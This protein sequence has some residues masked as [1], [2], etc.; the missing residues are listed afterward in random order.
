MRPRAHAFVFVLLVGAAAAAPLVAVLGGGHTLVWRDTA[1][2]GASLQRLTGTALR[3]LRLPQWNPHEAMGLPLL[4][5]P[6][7]AV[8]HPLTVLPAWVAPEAGLDWQIVLAVALA[9]AGAAL[10]ALTLGA[11]RWASAA[12]GVGWALSGY[13]L[14]MSCNTPYL[15]AGASA[16]WTAA[17]LLLAGKGSPW[18][19]PLAAL[20]TAVQLFAGDMQWALFVAILGSC[21][22]MAVGGWRGA[23]RASLAVALGALLGAV[24]LLP[25]WHFFAESERFQGLSP[26]ERMQ[27]ALAPWRLLEL[28]APGFFSG[29]SLGAASTPVFRALG[30]PS[31]LSLPFAPSVF[32]GAPVL[33]LAAAGVRAHRT[34]KVLAVAA[35]VA[36]WIALGYHLGADQLLRYVPVV[37]AFRY[38]EKLVGPFTLCALTLAA[39]GLDLVARGERKRLLVLA[40]AVAGVAAAAAL[41]LLAA[42][43]AGRQLFESVG[44]GRAAEAARAQLGLG[45]VHAAAA[46]AAVAAVLALAVG[47]RQ[48]LAAPALAASIVA[49]SAVAAP[50]AVHVGVP[51]E[52]SSPS[53]A[54]IAASES[55]PRISTPLP[56]NADGGRVAQVL[57]EG[58]GDLLDQFMAMEREM[59]VTSYAAAMGVGNVKPYAP[60]LPRRTEALLAAIQDET[61]LRRYGVTHVVARRALSFDDRMLA[62]AS[63][64]GGRHV[65]D[66]PFGRFEVWAV[67]HRPW[68]AFASSA[69]AVP[70]QDDAVRALVESASLGRTAVIVEAGTAPETAAGE[71]LAV[72]RAPERIL[73]D[74]QASGHGLLVVNDAFA[75]GWTA[76][77]DGRDVPILAA[78]VAV[79]AVQFPPGRHAL[80]M[81]YVAPGLRT[82]QALSILGLLVA[83]ALL[84]RAVLGARRRGDGVAGRGAS[85]RLADDVRPRHSSNE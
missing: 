73:I 22:A 23:V 15:L 60:T 41:F 62:E 76:S 40:V 34:A 47:P 11:S 54:A 10:L 51:L 63:T 61:W 58:G 56:Q 69:I 75:P 68:A 42:P 19:L 79:R 18:G 74:A 25:S 78:D 13:L 45:L 84:A 59:G 71:V 20:A 27:W 9:G 57:G 12:A 5:R 64:A 38:S 65:F 36:L 81:R 44:A 16:P 2:I 66:D 82:G 83:A 49:A 26:S 77:L 72:E 24:Q 4:A 70:T 35:A 55:V 31:A 6:D 48:R 8:L 80:E 7:H 39:L 50:F 53:L 85:A 30:G 52:R 17:A 29:G 1:K 33:F 43:G 37:G 32:V 14:G 3:E 67:P 21:L 46:L 28:V